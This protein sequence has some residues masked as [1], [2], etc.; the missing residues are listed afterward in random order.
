MGLVFRWSEFGFWTATIA[1][2]VIGWVSGLIAVH[3]RERV[4]HAE[5][6]HCGL[7][8][9]CIEGGRGVGAIE[10]LD[11]CQACGDSMVSE[12]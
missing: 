6:A 7:C 12:D 4:R 9:G 3:F 8:G 5:H 11:F 1:G 2:L 10:R